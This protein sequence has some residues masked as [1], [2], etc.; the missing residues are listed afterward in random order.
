[1]FLEEFQQ[2]IFEAGL[3]GKIS[4]RE[5]N[6]SYSCAMTTCSNEIDSD[7]YL[8]LNFIEFIE[9]FARVADR[10]SL[11]PVNSRSDIKNIVGNW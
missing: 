2:M 8:Y 11:P 6:L 9:A 1:L 5:I 3:L 10:L 7:R 4:E